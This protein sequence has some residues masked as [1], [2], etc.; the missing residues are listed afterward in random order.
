MNWKDAEKFKEGDII[1]FRSEN[2]VKR[3]AFVKLV[4]Y[5]MIVK[6]L[7]TNGKPY[8]KN[9]KINFSQFKYLHKID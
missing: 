1:E 8:T 7:K 2:A 6:R 3:Y 4:K 9:H 5:A